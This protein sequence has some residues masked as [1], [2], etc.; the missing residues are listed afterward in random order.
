VASQS[1]TETAQVAVSSRNSATAPRLAE[2]HAKGIGIARCATTATSH[3][4]LSADVATL[5]KMELLARPAATSLSARRKRSRRAKGIGSV[6]DAATTISLGEQN[7]SAAMLVKM[8]LKGRR[9]EAEAVEVDSE[10]AEADVVAED[11]V[12]AEIEV[13]AVDQEE[14]LAVASTNPSVVSITKMKDQTRR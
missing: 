7:A 8:E 4:A 5:A 1:L 11:E 2:K 14:A 9:L 13:V 6:R 10:E 12:V 3:R